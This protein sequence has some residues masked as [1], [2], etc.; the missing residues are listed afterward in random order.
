MIF[1]CI[2]IISHHPGLQP[3]LK[4]L[5]DILCHSCRTEGSAAEHSVAAS[6]MSIQL[7][8][9]E[10]L[11]QQ[12]LTHSSALLGVVMALHTTIGE[13]GM[14]LPE[15]MG[16]KVKKLGDKQR[17]LRAQVEAEQQMPLI[18]KKMEVCRV[19]V[20][21]L[22]VCVHS[23]YHNNY[24]RDCKPKLIVGMQISHCL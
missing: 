10:S 20:H 24:E 18:S 12:L 19:C 11:I 2:Q 7:G 4:Q 21:C 1:P 15:D 3:S 8:H 17:E 6:L 16:S 22:C 14:A 23:C 13:M 9:H 5:M